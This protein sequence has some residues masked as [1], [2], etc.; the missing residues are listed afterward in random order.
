[1]DPGSGAL[2]VGL[3]QGGRPPIQQPASQ[4]LPKRGRRNTRSRTDDLADL[5]QDGRLPLRRRRWSLGRRRYLEGM[6]S[7]GRVEA[8]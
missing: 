4:I 5:P 6:C 8:L 2:R 1:M 3:G 7:R